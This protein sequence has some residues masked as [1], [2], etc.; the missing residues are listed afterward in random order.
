[1]ANVLEKIATN[2]YKGEDKI[3]AELVQQAWIMG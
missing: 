3:V 2:L 1:M